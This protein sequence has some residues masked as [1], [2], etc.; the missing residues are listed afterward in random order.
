MTSINGRPD[1]IL[2]GAAGY[3]GQQLAKRFC[4]DSHRVFGI[5]C[6]NS[7]FKHQSFYFYRTDLLNKTDRDKLFVELKSQISVKHDRAVLFHLAG[8]SNQAD[9]E[10]DPDRCNRINR[11]LVRELLEKSALFGID[12]HV[13]LSSAQLYATS[14]SE[15]LNERADLDLD[16]A[17]A[18]SKF[19]AEQ[20]LRAISKKMAMYSRVIRI[21]N[22]YGESFKAGTVFE[23]I[24]RQIEGRIPVEV[25]DDKPVRDFVHID[26][27]IEGLIRVSRCPWRVAYEVIN[28]GTGRGTSIRQLICLMQTTFS[29]SSI[30]ST[31]SRDLCPGKVNSIILDVSKLLQMTGWMPEIDL[32]TGLAKMRRN[33]MNV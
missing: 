20:E 3:I 8:V 10:R 27:V 25:K 29:H 13:F 30:E 1:I 7:D 12:R 6:L 32:A 11:V 2:T 14:R 23:K 4:A 24:Y 31:D 33:L 22:T 5:D 21:S 19:G 15:A 18:R 16:S 26:D 9:C 17:Y 28:L